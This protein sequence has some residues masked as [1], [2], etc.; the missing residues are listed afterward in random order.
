MVR[1]VA[2]GVGALGSRRCWS[3]R[4]VLAALW[5]QCEVAVGRGAL[6]WVLALGSSAVGVLIALRQPRNAIGWVLLAAAVS[7]GEDSLARAFADH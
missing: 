5:D 4:T 6:V 2:C 3:A 1:R 7:V